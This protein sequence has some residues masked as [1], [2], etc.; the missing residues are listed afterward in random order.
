MK[1]AIIDVGGGLR[2]IFGAGVLD[3]FMDENITFDLAIGVSAGSGNLINFLANQ[4]GRNYLYYTDY[5]LR[6]ENMSKRNLI[7]KGCFLD[8]DYV[9]KT[10]SNSGGEN[11][12]DYETFA[13]NPTDFVVIATEAS[14]GNPKYFTKKDFQKDNYSVLKASAAIPWICK[15]QLIG[16]EYYFDG[17]LSDS[18][19]FEKAFEM[20]CDK[21]VIILNNPHDTFKDNSNDIKLAKRIKRKFPV[22]S[23]KMEV[24]S[25][26]YNESL[27]RAHELEKEG[28]ICIISAD[29]MFGVKTLT[30]D[31][32]ALKKLYDEGYKQGKKFACSD[33]LKN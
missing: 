3:S 24:K 28:K 23:A 29:D 12:L 31:L 2:G 7:K 33:F 30:K 15:P 17:A 22:A 21:V 18:V 26:L 32:E 8:L 16:E 6:K 9:F 19:P 11:P 4:R 14:T 5:A 10:L 27:K 25:V 1:T 13:A 20:G